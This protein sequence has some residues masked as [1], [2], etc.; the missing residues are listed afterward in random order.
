MLGVLMKNN[1]EYIES[2]VREIWEGIL[3]KDGI[4]IDD[5]FF[6][7][8]GDSF[9]A[10]I[11]S[12]RI[13]K[14]LNLKIPL[15]EILVNP[16]LKGLLEFIN[17]SEM[18]VQ[19]LIIPTAVS[20]FYSASLAQKGL[21]IL[22]EQFENIDTTY[23]LPVSILI[24]GKIDR[25]R[26]EEV[27]HTLIKRHESLRTSFK[28]VDGNLFQVVHEK[29]DFELG[30][31]Y[32]DECNV[33]RIMKEFVKPFDL[34]VA[35]LIR[36]LLV[37][38]DDIRFVLLIDTHHIISDGVS[39]R[40]LIR[41]IAD[42]YSGKELPPLEIQ[43]R[44]YCVWQTEM[45]RNNILSDQEK[46]WINVFSDK[47]PMLDL[48]TDF[49][50]PVLKSFEG[51][52]L[53]FVLGNALG[54]RLNKLAVETKTTLFM[55]LVTAYN[56]LLSKYTGQEDILIGTLASGRTNSKTDNLI[57][58]FINTLAL[59]SYPQN[60][61]TFL[62]LL[63]EIKERIVKIFENQDY[64]FQQLV[65][66]LGLTRDLARNPMFDVAFV[67]QNMGN[68][69][70]ELADLKFYP[71]EYM[72]MGSKF[73]LL[74]ELYEKDSE[75]VLT[76][77][78][79]TKLFKR[80]TIQMMALYYENILNQIS[81]NL[82]LTLSDITMMSDEQKN[83]VLID[84]NNTALRYSKYKTI[85][86]LIEE[87]VVKTPENTALVFNGSRLT[88]KELNEKSNQLARVIRAKGINPDNIVG[89]MINRSL[90]MVIGILGVLKA[91][92]AYLPIDPEYPKERIEYMLKDSGTKLLLTSGILK[93]RVEFDGE[94]MEIDSN[95]LYRGESINLEPLNKP[96]DLAYVIYTSGSTG[97][98]K[99]VMIEH[100]AVNNFIKGM[101]E[102]INFQQGKSIL[103]LTTISFDIFLL[104]IILPLTLGM[105]S[106]IA[107]E[108][109][110]RVPQLINQL[111]IENRI[112]I[113]QTT[114]SRLHLIMGDNLCK[115]VL[116]G[117]EYLLVGGEIFPQYLLNDLKKFYKG[118]IYNMYGPTET[119][120]WSIVKDLTDEDD[121]NIGKP[122]AN[123]QIYIVDKNNNLQSI[124]I[125]GELCISGDGLARGYLNKYELTEEKFVPNPFVF[126]EKMYRTGD[127]AKWLPNGE[128]LFLGRIDHQVKIRGFRIEL[129]EVQAQLLAYDL[130]KEAIVVDI[131]SENGEKHLCAYIATNEKINV[132]ELRSFLTKK[133]PDY[134]VPSFFVQLKKLPQ[135]PNGK[136]DRN[137]LPDPKN[138]SNTEVEYIAPE[139]EL[140][141]KIA[142][143]WQ[144]VLER[145]KVGIDEDFFKL[146]GH[147][148]LAIKLEV[149]MEKND[150]HVDYLDLYK[151]KTI[152]QIASY[153]ER[154][155]CDTSTDETAVHLS[156]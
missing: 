19:S 117:L 107:D 31:I 80:E 44:D 114:P 60:S 66:K 13:Q 67:M 2:K 133:I 123:T 46:Y 1:K 63:N 126:G 118:K 153:F 51:E 155:G 130:V 77:E 85:H 25:N 33:K 10:T 43:Y 121:I 5:D 104:E 111:I 94:T 151:Y 116:D 140:Q 83:S 22:E 41:E 141:S 81:T 65:A 50:R 87:Q 79:C 7:L 156:L 98:P 102:K 4:G 138:V 14:E 58:V 154:K 55:S 24:E 11:L 84:F 45:L 29:I 132:S 131:T 148:L 59:R 61:K 144:K 39:Y 9:K 149:E 110:Q 134:M 76:I 74:F 21:F 17:N 90:E 27:F 6:E 88:Y 69:A 108:R 16:T 95:N 48:P 68:P 143:I 145:D 86:K 147:S 15:G 152:R 36:S 91:G 103:A 82:F 146:G 56:I 136:I 78:Y 62:Q 96:T 128:I 28:F 142:M 99:G 139:T 127:L 42:I 20:D 71:Y 112:N 137:A 35:P 92:G 135:T 38:I 113:L 122:I 3:E 125:A 124:G 40:I 23:N 54:S 47:V 93:E 30:F 49:S 70:I 97:K 89:I 26:L 72:G 37:K 120:V 129:G 64:Q 12:S 52:R 18:T 109:Q 105:K 32:A 115:T 106:I 8:G 53:N 150:L 100:R 75:L 34:Y 119:T 73:D 57:G 101:T